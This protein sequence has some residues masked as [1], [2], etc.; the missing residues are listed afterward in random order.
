MEALGILL[1]DLLKRKKL[2]AKVVGLRK[3][4][5]SIHELPILEDGKTWAT[6]LIAQPRRHLEISFEHSEQGFSTAKELYVR[7]QSCHWP[8]TTTCLRTR[9]HHYIRRP[10]YPFSFTGIGA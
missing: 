6:R 9:M 1:I 7:K 10:R 2:V 4:P 3:S 5:S 8:R